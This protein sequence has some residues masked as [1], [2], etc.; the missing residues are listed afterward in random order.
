MQVCK[1]DKF[2]YE[3]LKGLSYIPKYENKYIANIFSQKPNFD[4]DYEMMEKALKW[5][6]IKAQDYNLSVAI[7]YGIGCGI[8]NGEWNEVY[9]IIKEVFENSNI[10]CTLYKL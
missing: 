2:N 3:E 8:A 4:T 1:E 9:K 7:P 10:Q 5:V 6:K